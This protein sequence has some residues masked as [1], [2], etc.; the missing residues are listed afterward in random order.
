MW[1][2][3]GLDTPARDVVR[4][5]PR[6]LAAVPPVHGK[7][8]K[9]C[10]PT[11][12]THRLPLGRRHA[13]AAHTRAGAP[14]SATGRSPAARRQPPWR[15]CR[16]SC[17]HNTRAKL[18]V[19]LLA[20]KNPSRVTPCAHP[21]THRPPPSPLAPPWR[22]CSFACSPARPSLWPPSQ[23]STRASSITYGLALSSHSPGTSPPRRCR[24]CLT[25]GHHRAVPRPSLR[26]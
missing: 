2:C 15:P 6:R 14:P 19:T 9:H 7:L 3:F 18:L 21:R 8:R 23:T 4:D 13:A 22:A 1:N 16:G 10:V 11:G 26:R 24:G 17:R 12:V 20:Y 5:L 25:A